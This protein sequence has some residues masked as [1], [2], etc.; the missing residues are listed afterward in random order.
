MAK[1]TA[2]KETISVTVTSIEIFYVSV[3]SSSPESA[4]AFG[5]GCGFEAHPTHIFLSKVTMNQQVD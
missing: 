2:T 3:H 4:K 5:V 1:H